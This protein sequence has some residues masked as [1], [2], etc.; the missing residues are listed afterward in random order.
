[1]KDTYQKLLRLLDTNDKKSFFLFILIS[2]LGGAIEV[3]GIGSV[4]PFIGVLIQPD[5]VTTN[6]ILSSIYTTLQFSSTSNFIIFMGCITLGTVMTGGTINILAIRFQLNLSYRIA[7]KW[8]TRLFSTYLHQPYK[9]YLGMNSNAMKSGILSEVDRTVSS[10]LIPSSVLI[11]KA[12]ILTV[13]FIM[14]LFINAAITIIL[15]GII[16]SIYGALLIYFRHKMKRRGQG[17]VEHNKTRYRVTSEAFTGIREIKLYHNAAYFEKKFAT[18]SKEYNMSQAYSLY[19][20][21]IPRFIIEIVG[22][23]ALIGLAIYLIAVSG[24]P[25][26]HVI[27]LI[28]LFAAAGYKILPASQNLYTSLN[29]IRF[30]SA[31]LA[32]VADGLALSPEIEEDNA[33]DKTKITFDHEIS[34]K[35]ISFAYDNQPTPALNNVNCTIKKNTL[36]TIMGPTGAGKSTFIDLLAGLLQPT[37]GEILIDGQTLTTANVRSWQRQIGYVPQKI[38]LLDGSIKDNITFGQPADLIDVD[39]ITVAA[40]KAQIDSYIMSLPDQYRAAVGEHGDHLSG[41][42]RQRVGIARALYRDPAILILD[43]PTSALDADTA[44]S[45]LTTLK[46]LSQEKTVII[47]THSTEAQKY[48]DQILFVSEGQIES[49]KTCEDLLK[50]NPSLFRQKERS[51]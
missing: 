20:G 43:E 8:T 41:G 12:M 14:L 29:K 51:Q 21:Q 45:L 38:H 9:F 34:V 39:Q 24:N 2:F 23:S 37:A 4:M 15:M 33:D 31:S 40:K 26:N 6:H 44:R 25:A 30:N 28:A 19:F 17:M 48:C 10:V 46:E 11:S 35:N 49:G 1:M 27:P 42:Q 16:G 47:I 13:I 3:A 22:F 7:H 18:A 32:A 5:L 36:V 50:H